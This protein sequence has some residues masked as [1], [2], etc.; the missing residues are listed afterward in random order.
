MVANLESRLGN[1]E[2][3]AHKPKVKGS[4]PFAATKP[5][6]INQS[7]ALLRVLFNAIQGCFFFM[8]EN[9]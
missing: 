7:A 3:S 5:L 2:L 1:L 9:K 4:T 8:G 6:K